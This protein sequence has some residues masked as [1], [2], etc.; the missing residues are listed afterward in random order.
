MMPR[1]SFRFNECIYH[2]SSFILYKYSTVSPSSGIK[3]RFKNSC[4]FRTLFTISR[5]TL[6][7]FTPSRCVT[8]NFASGANCSNFYHIFIVHNNASTQAKAIATCIK[9]D[10]LGAKTLQIAASHQHTRWYLRRD[11]AS[12]LWM[13]EYI[14][15]CMSGRILMMKLPCWL[16]AFVCSL[17]QPLYCRRQLPHD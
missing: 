11:R 13:S 5:V 1:T 8:N 2:I 10:N 7:W 16:S 15:R 17:P 4:H 12:F 3:T 14:T 9:G 6:L